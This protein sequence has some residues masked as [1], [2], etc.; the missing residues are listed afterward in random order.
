MVGVVDCFETQHLRQTVNRPF[1]GR[2]VYCFTD[3][4]NR[5]DLGDTCPMMKVAVLDDYLQCIG[6]LA[7]WDSLGSDVEV[8]FFAEAIP[9]DAL[10]DR[11]APFD[12]IVMLRER[13][14]FPKEVLEGLPNLK[15]LI[16]DGMGNPAVDR[17]TLNERGVVFCGTA[18]VGGT[19]APSSPGIPGPAEMAWALIFALA[20]RT[21]QEDR[22]MRAG[23]WQTGMPVNLRGRTLG[24]AGLGNLGGAMVKPAHA[25]GMNV[26]AW[27]ENLTVERAEALGVEAVRKEELLERSDVLGIFL[28]L[29]ERTRGLFTRRDLEMMKPSA[30][31]VNIS[32]GPIIEEQA[33]IDCLRSGRIV[34]AGLDVYDVEPLPKDHPLRSMENVV[35]SPHLGY[36]NEPGLRG[37][38]TDAVED[39]ARFI[40][41]DPIRIID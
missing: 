37:V 10:R 23:A 15:L 29:S 14:R 12:V 16:T 31:V 28:R 35:L 26:V 36:V 1:L 5:P 9:P 13:T 6:E 30:F 34:G 7:D 33:L 22:A 41:G 20:K 27:S 19:P 4:D 24:L 32:R 3:L 21:A 17:A 39:I 40:A 8:T 38:Y 11:L 18:L 25:F 2:S